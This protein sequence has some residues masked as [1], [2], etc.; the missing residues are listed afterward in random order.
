MRLRLE[1]AG[2]SAALEQAD[3]ERDTHTEQFG[4]LTRGTFLLVH[5]G[6]DSLTKISRIGTH[7]DLLQKGLPSKGII[8]ACNPR[9]NRCK[10]GFTSWE[11]E[12]SYQM[13]WAL[14]FEETAVDWDK[15]LKSIEAKLLFP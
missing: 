5:G 10:H 11:S 4:D 1:R 6:R 9:V 13:Y 12:Q 7:G 3:D 15:S 2:L 8:R 14:R